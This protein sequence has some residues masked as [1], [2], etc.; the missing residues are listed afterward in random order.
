MFLLA[1]KCKGKHK[2]CFLEDFPATATALTSDN[3][4]EIG[5]VLHCIDTTKTF[6][7][8]LQ[9]I[10]LTGIVLCVGLAQTAYQIRGIA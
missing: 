1:C 6:R 5:L 8:A 4:G 2:T 3:N 10:Q 7:A 9:L